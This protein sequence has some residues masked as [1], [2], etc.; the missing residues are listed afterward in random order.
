MN[1]E[2]R[3]LTFKEIQKLKIKINE[4]SY[5]IKTYEKL[6]KETRIQLSEVAIEYNKYLEFYLFYKFKSLFGKQNI[7]ILK[8]RDEILDR[9]EDSYQN[10]KNTLEEYECIVRKL[11]QEKSYLINRFNQ[12]E[13]KLQTCDKLILQK[14]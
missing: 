4:N 9:L 13:N 14:N 5:N 2:K 11:T 10:V 7:E 6:V 3:N 1:E 8:E 12:L